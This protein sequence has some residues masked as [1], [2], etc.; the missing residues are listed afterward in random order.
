MS[1]IFISY[2]SGDRERVKVLAE[3]LEGSAWSVWWDRK[4]PPGKTFAQIIKEELDAAKCVVVLWSHHSVK[5]EWVQNEAAQGAGRKILVPALIDPVE[6]PFEF[7][8]IQAA[9]LTDWNREQSHPGFTMFVNAISEIVGAPPELK[10]SQE[11]KSIQAEEKLPAGEGAQKSAFK[12]FTGKTL[13]IIISAAI[14]AG[15]FRIL[16]PEI[17]L[18]E[19]L[20]V[21][22]IISIITVSVL[23]YI[24]TW[25][26]RRR[27]GV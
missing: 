9:D 25:W 26:R 2:A 22:I 20:V 3:I 21:I 11:K 19:V 18:S 23:S 8:R 7:G 27:G 14:F 15:L 5:S 10:P 1:D 16:Y 4:I 6:I 13:M 24:W 17:A 12:K